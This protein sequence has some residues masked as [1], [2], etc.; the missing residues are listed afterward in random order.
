MN[1]PMK[2]KASLRALILAGPIAALLAVPSVHAATLLWDG[3]NGT[4]GFGTASGTWAA[5]TTGTATAGWTTD[6]TG[7]TAIS[8]N[9]V[10]TLTTDTLNFGNGATGLAA[11]TIT[12]SGTVDAG[13][14]TFASASGAI[15][16]SGGT[17]NLAAAETITVNNATNTIGSIL[18]G[19]ATS[20]TKAGNGILTLSGANTYAGTTIINAG[21]LT[22]NR[23]TGSLDTSSALTFTGTGTFNMDNAGA[24]GALTQ[25]L[26]ALAFSTGDG[27]VKTT[28]TANFDQAITFA[29]LT[30]S[31]GAT[32]NFVNTG[33]NSATNGFV[34][35]S[36]PTA[37]QIIDPGYFYNGSSYA[38]YDSGGFVR[39][40]IYGTDTNANASLTGAQTTL[41]TI[42][43]S[44]D[45]QYVAT[46]ATN[47][48]SNTASAASTTLVVGNGAL[49]KVGAPSRAPALP[50]ILMSP[51]FP[52]IP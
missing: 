37:S 40:L 14:M 44:I 19:A 26:G 48:T 8:G 47:S 51:P 32:G 22:L 34:F 41:G 4:A 45:T 38:A 18:A 10:T 24:S 7:A 29:S 2:S 49:F 12:V 33:T 43:A 21:T 17:I 25:T 9:S 15:V 31:A 16:L 23:Q 1:S 5:P 28:R 46:T 50:R 27:T 13:N 6:L 20:F 36:A 30:R 39:G 42:G 11:G 35:T 52:A 3:N